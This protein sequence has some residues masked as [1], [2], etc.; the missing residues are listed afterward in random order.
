MNK[1][2]HIHRRLLRFYDLI[3]WWGLLGCVLCMTSASSMAQTAATSDGVDEYQ[4]KAV[5]IYNFSKFVEWPASSFAD[6]N[7]NFEICVVGYNPFGDAL[8]L[9]TRRSYQTHPIV[10]R[11]PQNT[12]DAKAC[13]ILYID[14]SVKS[15][16]WHEMAKGLGDAA[17]LT[18]SNGAESAQ[19]GVGIGFVSRDGKIRWVLN[20]NATRKAQLKVSAKLVEIATDII[21]DTSK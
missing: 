19:S 16:Q 6:S 7:A 11:Y 12:S 21:G 8:N 18:V 10:I 13:H 14:D 3:R 15:T 5:F 2:I 20:L 9:L 17:I 4:L 1:R